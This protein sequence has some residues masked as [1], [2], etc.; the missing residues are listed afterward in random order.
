MNRLLCVSNGHGED[1]IALPVLQE[2]RK[3]ADAPEIAVLPIVGMGKAFTNNG[4]SIAG[5]VRTMPS[6]GFLNMDN[7]ELVKDIRGGLIGLTKSQYQT[8]REWGKNGGEILAVGDIVPLLLAWLSGANYSFIGTAKSEYYL[9]DGEGNIL[10]SQRHSWEVRTG[11]YYFPWE[12]WLMSRPSCRAVFVRDRLTAEILQKYHIPAFDLGNPMMDGVAIDDSL[13]AD[14]ERRKQGM[15]SSLIITLLPGSRPPEAARNWQ[16]IIIALDSV[17]SVFKPRPIVGLA[18]IAPTL[19]I[20]SLEGELAGNGWQKLTEGRED[21]AG[22]ISDR[23]AIYYQ[24]EDMVLILT[25]RAY[26]ECMHLGDFAIAMAGTATEQFV[27]LGKP[28]VTIPGRG[29]QFTPKFAELQTRLLGESIILVDHPQA[30]G[31]QIKAVLNQPKR[32]HAIAVNGNLRMGKPGA[33]ARIARHLHQ[34]KS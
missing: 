23:D 11:S 19:D 8:M 28:A 26:A 10:P 4:F 30:V 6:G 21:L 7:R 24:R 17:I 29:P 14:L 16:Q 5:T 27:G 9:R 31:E 25:N 33:A 12:R 2:L 22:L 13:R 32:L 15:A 3:F 1:A 18:A 34:I 20:T